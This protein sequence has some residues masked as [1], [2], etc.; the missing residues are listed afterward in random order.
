MSDFLKNMMNGLGDMSPLAAL[1][2]GNPQ[3]AGNTLAHNSQ[4]VMGAMGGMPGMPGMGKPSG[5]AGQP[6]ASV[7][8]SVM[9]M[10]NGPGGMPFDE[11]AFQRFLMQ[12][13]QQRPQV[14]GANG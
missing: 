8:G 1:I 9:P 7:H 5:F 13:M 11:S 6:A 4:I 14:L 12:Q 2:A 10:P 3:Q